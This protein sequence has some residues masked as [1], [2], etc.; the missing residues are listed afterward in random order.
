MLEARLI[1]VIW[2]L[3]PLVCFNIEVAFGEQQQQINNSIAGNKS[4]LTGENRNEKCT[5]A[6]TEDKC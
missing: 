4:S 3:F 5:W 2:M 6:I 1:A